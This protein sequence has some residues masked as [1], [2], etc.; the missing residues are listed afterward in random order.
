MPF[1]AAAFE[2]VTLFKLFQLE[3]DYGSLDKAAL[4]LDA[5]EAKYKAFL[6]DSQIEL[7]CKN[8]LKE[9]YDSNEA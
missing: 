4:L 9:N 6:A 5:Y 1:F 7:E 3:F 2:A 8:F